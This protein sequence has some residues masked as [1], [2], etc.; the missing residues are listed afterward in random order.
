MRDIVIL[1][2][3]TCEGQSLP[4]T[5][6]FDHPTVRQLASV[7][8]S[9]PKC[10]SAKPLANTF[11][12]A[13]VGASINGLSALLP[14]GASSAQLASFAV[15]CGRDAIVQVPTTRW[16]VRAQPALPELITS[17]VRHTKRRERATETDER[18]A[19]AGARRTADIQV[20]VQ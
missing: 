4:S 16:D 6:V 2:T 12:C 5:I 14:S 1:H 17:R 11:V 9:Q 3:G 15:A 7:L 20:E 8:Q 18:I 10:A 13:G 19:R